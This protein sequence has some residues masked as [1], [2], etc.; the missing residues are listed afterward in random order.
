MIDH[1]DMRTLDSLIPTRVLHNSVHVRAVLKMILLSER[2]FLLD[3]AIAE[4]IGAQHDHLTHT[5]KLLMEYHEL[6]TGTE[7][8]R[9][10]KGN[11]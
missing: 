9:V 8:I 3:E 7:Y 10:A 2:V 1:D 4:V 11:M 5:E 6:G